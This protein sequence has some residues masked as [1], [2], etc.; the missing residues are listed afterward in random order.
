[1]NEIEPPSEPSP[2]DPELGALIARWRGALV[3]MLRAWGS[4]EAVDLAQDVFAEAWLG[5]ERFDGDWTDD[6]RVGPWL[7]GIAR[8]LNAAAARERGRRPALVEVAIDRLADPKTEH[9]S[10]DDRG[11]GVRAAIAR[12]PEKLGMPIWMHYLE[13][14]PVRRVAALL[15]VPEKTVEGRLYR[16]R[17]E[18]ARMLGDREPGRSE[19]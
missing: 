8:N 19:R 13:R 3:G 17:R 1:L 6:A 2:L 7:R 5:R 4:V 11:A 14:T 9:D 12:L 15:G 16:A 10:A 18:L